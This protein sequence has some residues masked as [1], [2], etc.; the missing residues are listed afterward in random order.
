[1]EAERDAGAAKALRTGAGDLSSP[2]NHVVI[3]RGF[4]FARKAETI[5]LWSD[6]TQVELHLK[7]SAIRT[8]SR[9]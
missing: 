7:F 9:L 2:D 4:P 1:V 6:S 8:K 3:S 5:L